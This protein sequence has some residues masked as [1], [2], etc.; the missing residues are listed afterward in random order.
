MPI[1][2]VLVCPTE[3]LPNRKPIIIRGFPDFPQDNH[4]LI[5]KQAVIISSNITIIDNKQQWIALF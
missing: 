1:S 2:L 3:M 4:K 5:K